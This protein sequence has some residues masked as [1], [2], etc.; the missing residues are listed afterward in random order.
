M[1]DAVVRRGYPSSTIG[2]LVCD[3]MK[4]PDGRTLVT[5][6]QE[7]V[8]RLSGTPEPGSRWDR[9]WRHT[10]GQVWCVLPLGVP[11]TGLA[12]VAAGAVYL[13]P[14]P[15]EITRETRRSSAVDPRCGG[16]DHRPG[17]DP[18]PG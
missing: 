14:T 7:W 18:W 13:T 11:V 6:V 12:V 16:R 4:V 15:G 9:R 8:T 3:L 17:R 1:D 2:R 5:A 10:L